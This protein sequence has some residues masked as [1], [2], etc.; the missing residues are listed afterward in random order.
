MHFDGNGGK[1]FELEQVFGIFSVEEQFLSFYFFQGVRVNSI[2]PAFI[3]T[4]FMTTATGV[5]KDDEAYAEVIEN[6][7][8]THPIGRIGNTQDCVNAISFLAKDS[9]SFITGVNLP[10]DGGKSNFSPES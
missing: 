8:K 1:R 9:S 3:E 7:T 10:V 2:N 4:D 6:T 5:E